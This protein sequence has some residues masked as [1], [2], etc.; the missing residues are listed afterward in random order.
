MRWTSDSSA[1]ILKQKAPGE[2][3]RLL[4]S[5]VARRSEARLQHCRCPLP[6]ENEPRTG[7]S[8]YAYVSDR[9]GEHPTKECATYPSHLSNNSLLVSLGDMA[10]SAAA[11]FA[12]ASTAG[13]V[14]YLL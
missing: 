9:M 8:K 13:L 3:R 5:D 11:A 2:P 7:R 4:A 14:V 1:A 10:A 6:P 12:A